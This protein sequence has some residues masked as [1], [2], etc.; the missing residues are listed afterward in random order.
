MLDQIVAVRRDL[1][2]HAEPAWCEFRTTSKIVTALR[3]LGLPVKYGAAVIRDDA[4]MGLPTARELDRFSRL[5]IE[6]G[7]DPDI[8]SEIK[9]GFTGAVATIDG[10]HRGPT[11]ALRFDID[12]NLGNEAAS[13]NHLP[14]REGFVSAN[15]G[16]HHNCGHDGHTAIGLS[17]AK[18]LAKSR[19]SQHGDIRIIFQPAEEGL[20]GAAAMVAAGVLDGVDYLL[21]AHLGVKSLH[22]GEI[23]AGYRNILASTK[24]DVAF[25]GKSAHAALSPHLGHNALLAACSATQNLLAMPRHGDGETRV[26]VGLL[27]AGQSRNAIPAEAKLAAE[28]RADT[29]PILRD[30]EERADRIFKGAALMHGVE[31]E[32]TKVGS[33]CSASSDPELMDLISK[34][35]PDVQGVTDLRQTDDFKASDDFAL[36]MAAVQAKGGKAVYFG[37]GTPLAEVHHNPHFDFDE[38]AMPIG[39]ELF[40]KAVKRLGARQ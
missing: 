26:N 16:V 15:Q 12:A 17:V 8:L 6:S 25:H 29:T 1:H 7:A 3:D 39:V 35:A 10:A 24:L 27:S 33:A 40:V 9:G 37:L 36:M 4:R 21:G 23:I 22:L 31:V 28:L 14:A 30:L 38:R 5:A 18:I 34:V 11:I 13:P 2:R 20:R 32:T 19:E